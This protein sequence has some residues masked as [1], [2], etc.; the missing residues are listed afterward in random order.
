MKVMDDTSI[1]VFTYLSQLDKDKLVFG[2]TAGN[3]TT[4]PWGKN[5]EGKK[6]KKEG[7][8]IIQISARLRAGA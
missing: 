6:M 1:W 4:L 3:D 2:G 7:L 5:A 8:V